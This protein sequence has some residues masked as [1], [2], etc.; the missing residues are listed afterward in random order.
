MRREM[1]HAARIRAHLYVSLGAVS[2]AA[3]CIS[4]PKESEKDSTVQVTRRS[5]VRDC[6]TSP[7]RRAAS[8]QGQVRRGQDFST[9]LGGRWVLRLAPRSEGWLL[10]VEEKDRPAEDLAR[11]TPPWHFVPNP[12][13]IEGWHFRNATN[14]GPNDGSTNA[15][16]QLREF[17]FSPEVGRSIEYRGAMTSEADVERVGGFGQGW[18]HLDEYELTPPAR[19][20]R[21]GFTSIAFTACLTWRDRSTPE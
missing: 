18:L 14:T 7:G 13:E 1:G 9:V 21:A 16:Q 20:E 11:L 4:P 15:P 2:F 5:G 12:R 6:T 19:G 3:A 8:I 10:Q 17:I